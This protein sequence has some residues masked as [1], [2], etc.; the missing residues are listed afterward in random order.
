[1][2]KQRT[3]ATSRQDLIG[4]FIITYEKRLYYFWKG[5][6]FGQKFKGEVAAACTHIVWKSKLSQGK[7]GAELLTQVQA[8]LRV[9]FGKVQPNLKV[10]FFLFLLK[11][12]VCIYI[13]I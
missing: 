7:S 6:H 9:D 12:Y 2:R 13:Y 8:K 10:L 11:E 1:M 3:L 4:L 5:T